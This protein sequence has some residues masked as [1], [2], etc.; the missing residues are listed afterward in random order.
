MT[1]RLC[2][3]RCPPRWGATAT[4]CW[5]P[6]GAEPRSPAW[7]Q[8]A[9]TRSCSTWPCASRTVLR[10][11]GGFA[12]VATGRLILMLT[13]RDLV[14]DRVAGLDAGA[15]DYLVKPL[16]LAQMRVRLR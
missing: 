10:C 14:D 2:A 11:A 6:T 13:A 12:P 4:R 8:R 1:T 3:N 7:R 9:S 16:A 5:P 15:D